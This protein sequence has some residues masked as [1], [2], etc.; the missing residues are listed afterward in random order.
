[1]SIHHFQPVP[2][3]AGGGG[4]GSMAIVD[5]WN[6]AIGDGYLAIKD[7]T[8][9]FV[10][11]KQPRDCVSSKRNWAHVTLLAKLYQ[12]EFIILNKTKQPTWLNMW[13]TMPSPCPSSMGHASWPSIHG[14][15]RQGQGSYLTLGPH[16]FVCATNKPHKAWILSQGSCDMLIHEPWM[17]GHV[18]NVNLRS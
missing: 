13:T 9:Q 3:W 7:S 6:V 12:W 5:K 8:F 16:T 10:E 11:E 14:P 2:V 17:L 18:E 15:M 1:M 4:G